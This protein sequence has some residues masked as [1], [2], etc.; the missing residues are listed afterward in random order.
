MSRLLVALAAL[1]ASALVAAPA[2]ASEVY[3][4]LVGASDYGR[5]E[6]ALRDAGDTQ[7]DRVNLK[8]ARNDAILMAQALISRGAKAGNITLL[9]ENPEQADYPLPAGVKVA[10]SPTRS[11][12]VAA[13]ERLAARASTGDQVVILLSGHGSQQPQQGTLEADGLDEIFIPVDHG[14]W[15]GGKDRVENAIVDDEVADWIEAIRAK[16][17]DVIFIGDFCH[18]GDSVR[19]AAGGPAGIDF[20]RLLG[21]PKADVDAAATTAMETFRGK[22]RQRDSRVEVASNSAGK[23]GFV[24]F[25]AAAADTRADQVLGPV[26]LPRAERKPN[27]VLTM[28]LAAALTDPSVRTYREAATRVQVGYSAQNVPST[29]EFEGDLDTPVLGDAG[30][31]ASTAWT[32]FKPQAT[33]LT[34]MTLNAGALQGVT[35]GAIVGLSEIQLAQAGKE[36]VLL[37]GRVESVSAGTAR[38]VPVAYGDVPAER[39]GDI[40]T[41]SGGKFGWS[42]YLVARLVQNGAQF[43]FEVARPAAPTAPT[44]RQRAATAAID[45]L[46]LEA[47]GAKLRPAG[48]AADF[49]LRFEGDALVISQ[50]PAAGVAG[51]EIGRIDLRD[52]D[53]ARDPSGFLRQRIGDALSRTLRAAKLRRLVET[54]NAA[55]GQD[56]GTD[57]AA[58]LT[59]ETRIWFAPAGSGQDGKACPAAPLFLAD[60]AFPAGTSQPR[61]PRMD[62]APTHQSSSPCDT[63]Y[64]RLRNG[65]AAGVDVT[66][67]VI[68]PTAAVGSMTDPVYGVRLEPGSTAVYAWQ[69][70][71]MTGRSSA[72]SDIAFI[73][74]QSDPAVR[75]HADYAYLAQCAATDF[76]CATGGGTTRGGDQPFAQG[77]ARGFADMLDGVLEGRTRSGAVGQAVGSSGVLLYSWVLE[78]RP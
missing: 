55:P 63:V 57:P 59:V 35:E 19:G 6:K 76:S 1:A 3:S 50:S 13:M 66:G 14:L 26:Y 10:G 30:D 21:I 11:Q 48:D 38:L 47:A 45:A 43:G 78:P 27:G 56:A 24:A 34:S 62:Q 58:S 40:R 2:A 72:I 42:A 53:S 17:A 67:L 54:M 15:T 12:I 52:S 9:I 61:R 41:A 39:W 20:R 70:D 23:G 5:L 36:T 31:A 77:R 69:F 46:G 28:Y 60:R 37:Y 7:A 16:G 65:A 73:V 29:P 64:F 71:P 74:V 49:I 18:S 44:T 25:M 68:Q 51:S 32:V 33:S 8:G 75:I 22:P 4:V